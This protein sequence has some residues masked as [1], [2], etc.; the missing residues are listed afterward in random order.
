MPRAPC[1]AL[2]LAALTVHCGGPQRVTLRAAPARSA[3]VDARR[4]SYARLRPVSAST[5]Q[6]V[7]V[8]TNQTIGDADIDGIV[9]KDGTVVKDPRDLLP[10]VLPES[11]TAL[12]A[13]DFG[14]AQTA[15]SSWGTVAGLSA[16]VGA[17]MFVFGLTGQNKDVTIAGIATLGLGVLLSIPVFV[18]GG[19]QTDAW[20]AVFGAY[21]DDLRARLGLCPSDEAC[22]PVEP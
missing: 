21:D 18:Y 2:L 8:A 19:R 20:Q 13:T 9:L 3:D 10:V 4:A 17:G 12:A 22:D 16:G 11:P 15:S 1:L 7:D 6:L 14:R 5:V